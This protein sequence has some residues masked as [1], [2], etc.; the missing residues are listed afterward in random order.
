[1]NNKPEISKKTHEI[2]LENMRKHGI[3]NKEVYK[4]LYEVKNSNL[5]SNAIKENSPYAILKKTDEETE[6]FIER[7]QVNQIPEKLFTPD[8]C[9]KSKNIKRNEKIEDI[10]LAPKIIKEKVIK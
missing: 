9:K 5:M 8:I 7:K 1:M 2:A 3:E 4:R 6:Y 10:L